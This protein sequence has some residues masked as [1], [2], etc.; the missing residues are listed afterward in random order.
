MKKKRDHFFIV[1]VVLFGPIYFIGYRIGEWINDHSKDYFD[2]G[3]LYTSE[4]NA[5]KRVDRLN[6]E[7][8]KGGE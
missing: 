4:E 1:P 7:W 5:E 3:D 8:D 2:H 6:E